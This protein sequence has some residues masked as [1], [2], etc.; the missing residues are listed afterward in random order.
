MLSLFPRCCAASR[1]S[2]CFGQQG[3]IDDAARYLRDAG[4]PD[5]GRR[6]RHGGARVGAVSRAARQPR[7]TALVLGAATSLY[8]ARGAFGAVGRA[9][10]HDLA[11]RGGPRLRQA[12]GAGPRLDAGRSSCSCSSPSSWS[13][14]A[15]AL[16]GDVLRQIGLGDTSRPIWRIAR[17][18]AALL[19]AMLIYAIVYYAAPNVEIRRF[20]LDHARARCS[21]C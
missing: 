14:S 21:G 7:S 15:A 18:P 6:R 2:G 16:A 20:Q 10:N 12:Q 8:G 4:A 9:L 3:L 19:V 1:C 11:R 5:D 17:W 13:S